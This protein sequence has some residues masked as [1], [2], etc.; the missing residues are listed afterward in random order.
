MLHISLD[1]TCLDS[2]PR[3]QR[4][5]LANFIL[6]FPAVDYE[7]EGSTLS[8]VTFPEI[9]ENDLRDEKLKEINRLLKEIVGEPTHEQMDAVVRSVMAPSS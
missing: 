9:S 2:L 5:A 1:V 6:A 3:S 7:E 4:E 8:S